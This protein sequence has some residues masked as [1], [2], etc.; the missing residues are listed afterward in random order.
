MRREREPGAVMALLR[1][2][3]VLLPAVPLA[4]TTVAETTVAETIIPA[5]LQAGEH[6]LKLNG[7]GMREQLLVGAY[8]ACLYLTEPS[9]DAPRI[10]AADEPQAVSM[11]VNSNLLTRQRL[12]ATLPKDLKQSTGG[13]F[14]RFR[15][16]TDQ[17]LAMIDQEVVRGDV[18]R[19]I[20]LPDTGLQIWHNDR[21]KGVIEGLDFKR[22]LF[23]IWLSE[24]PT[25]SSLKR[26]MLRG[27]ADSTQG[28]IRR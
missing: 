10:L 8:I 28:S 7:A 21:L 2:L 4:T 25:Q 15:A 26:A 17:L 3:L 14:G 22:A 16:K 6:R 18:F 9:A 5:T 24:R 11:H 1:T 12:I 13:D 27:A 23:G 19:L 20:Y